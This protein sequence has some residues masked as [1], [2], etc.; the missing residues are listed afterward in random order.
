[1]KITKRQLRRIIREEVQKTLI[2]EASGVLGQDVQKAPGMKD[3][4]DRNIE[5]QDYDID[6]DVGT[7]WNFNIGGD[8]IGINITGQMKKED[9]TWNEDTMTMLIQDIA[10]ESP[11]INEKTLAYAITNNAK[12]RADVETHD[13]EI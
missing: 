3:I 2:I 7:E 9:G 10:E 13:K 8:E 5:Y 12:F 11:G 6:P 1:M 4:I